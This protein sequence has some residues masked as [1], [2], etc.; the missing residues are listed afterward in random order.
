MKLNI[1]LFVTAKLSHPTEKMNLI[2]LDHLWLLLRLFYEAA[3]YASFFDSAE[4]FLFLNF[5]TSILFD[6][7]G[8]KFS[9]EFRSILMQ[10]Q[11]QLFQVLIG[12]CL[13][14]PRL[15]RC[16]RKTQLYAPL[17]LKAL[18]QAGQLRVAENGSSLSAAA[19]SQSAHTHS[20]S[21]YLRDM[22]SAAGE[23]GKK[24]C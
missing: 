4:N 21:E 23:A 22:A 17:G 20:D 11:A 16:L 13:T 2:Y 9:L 19:M 7:P 10:T 6:V 8:T 3:S 14:E 24:T 12:I 1:A 5:S 15:A 18:F